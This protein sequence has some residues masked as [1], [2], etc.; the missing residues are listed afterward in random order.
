MFSDIHNTSKRFTLYLDSISELLSTSETSKLNILESMFFSI[1]KISLL[2]L[3]AR[4]QGTDGVVRVV[5]KIF[6]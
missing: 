3:E 6:P 4:Y 1:C 2:D 5:G